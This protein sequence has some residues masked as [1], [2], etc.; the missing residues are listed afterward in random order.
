LYSKPALNYA[1]ILYRNLTKSVFF[2]KN[3]IKIT[4]HFLGEENHKQSLLNA[5]LAT[6]VP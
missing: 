5:I 6:F 3:T 4:V 2:D 1:V